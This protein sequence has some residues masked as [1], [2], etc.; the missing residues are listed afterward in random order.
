MS[1]T[2]YT[3]KDVWRKICSTT[4][5]NYINMEKGFQ[6]IKEYRILFLHIIVYF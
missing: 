6:I 3:N 4:L 2:D 1:T 5:S